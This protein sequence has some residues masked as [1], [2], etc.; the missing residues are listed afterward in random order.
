[1]GHEQRLKNHVFFVFLKNYHMVK[2][3]EKKKQ[4][5]APKTYLKH[6][7]KDNFVWFIN[8]KNKYQTKPLREGVKHSIFKKDY[9]YN[10]PYKKSKPILENF[11]GE[12]LEPK[13]EKIMSNISNKQNLGLET[14]KLLIEWL[15]MM[16]FRSSMFRDNLT[17]NVTWINYMRKQLEKDSTLSEN[18]TQDIFKEGKQMGKLLQISTFL[19]DEDNKDLK[20]KFYMDFMCRKWVI[21]TSNTKN[22]IT[23]DNPGYSYSISADL[24]RLG[25]PSVSS[26]YNLNFDARMHVFPLSHNKCLQIYL[27]KDED[28]V[29]M[30]NIGIEEYIKTPI[31]FHEPEPFEIDFTNMCTFISAHE[32]I[33]GKDE[34]DLLLYC[35]KNK[36]VFNE[37]LQI[38]NNASIYSMDGVRSAI[39]LLNYYFESQGF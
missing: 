9:Y 14:K 33:I 16:N 15:F 38:V 17:R 21:C 28:V 34:K 22:F 20:E 18:E 27:P 12:I 37:I 8:K 19:D 31:E 13:Y 5:I 7:S 39:L 2:M 4:H 36:Q 25:R 11:F 23:S 1:V 32:L 35:S 3:A 6:F 24:V 10:F 29:K 26:M 30:R